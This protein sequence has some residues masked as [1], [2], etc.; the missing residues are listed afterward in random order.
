MDMS[1]YIALAAL[2]VSLLA[3]FISFTTKFTDFAKAPW[4]GI[5]LFLAGMIYVCGA[6]FFFFLWYSNPAAMSLSERF[7]AAF[8]LLFGPGLIVYSIWHTRKPN[9]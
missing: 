5:F 9:S 3:L 6:I 8:L 4:W 1:S 2:A 7:F